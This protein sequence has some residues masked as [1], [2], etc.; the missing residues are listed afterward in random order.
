MQ[1]YVT[2]PMQGFDSSVI[3]VPTRPRLPGKVAADRDGRL[4]L[5]AHSDVG[6]LNNVVELWRYPSAQGCIHARQAAR[7][8]PGWREAIGAVTPSVQHF[9]S[10]F[11]HPTSFS[12][13]Q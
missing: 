12:P 7:G 6:L 2:A 8:V 9:Q 3:P 4:V 11:L 5:F 10:S 13:W 1:R